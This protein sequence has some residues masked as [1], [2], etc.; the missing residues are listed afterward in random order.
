[1][2]CVMA[3]SL[4]RAPALDCWV[5]VRACQQSKWGNRNTKMTWKQR[6]RKRIKTR[7]KSCLWP[8][9]A[10]MNGFNG[11]A[12]KDWATWKAKCFSRPIAVRKLSKNSGK[13]SEKCL[14][15]KNFSFWSRI[16]GLKMLQKWKVNFIQIKSLRCQ[17]FNYEINFRRF[18]TD[19]KRL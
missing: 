14:K 5:S 3:S 1:M 6:F 15:L 16:F 4:L 7:V 10:K 17:I 13:K 2:A 11:P 9:I 18:W 19:W 12:E 8:K